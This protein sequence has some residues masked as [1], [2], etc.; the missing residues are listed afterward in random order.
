MVKQGTVT[1]Y[2]KDKKHGYISSSEL[3]DDGEEA[4]IFFHISDFHDG[5]PKEGATVMFET[6]EDEKGYRTIEVL[7]SSEPKTINDNSSGEQE[8]NPLKS[9]SGGKNDLLKGER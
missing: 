2:K 1:C 8:T 7:S 9:S 4:E 3:G 6:G 5:F